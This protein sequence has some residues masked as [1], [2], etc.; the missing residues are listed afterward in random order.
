M[1]QKVE[2]GNKNFQSIVNMCMS[3]KEN[4]HFWW[5]DGKFQREIKIIKIKHMENL[6]L[7]KSEMKISLSG[8]N[9]RLENTEESNS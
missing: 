7:K 5:R 6:E 9:S 3:L 4:R 1:I 8:L 2:L